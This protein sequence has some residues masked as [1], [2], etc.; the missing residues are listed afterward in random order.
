MNYVASPLTTR[1]TGM[2]A[3]GT[4]IFD[5]R[6]H[7]YNNMF[8][9]L[10]MNTP[11]LWRF[12]NDL[13]M[14]PELEQPIFHYRQEDILTP[15]TKIN[16]A[17]GYAADATSLVVDDSRPFAVN[18]VAYT[19]LNDGAEAMLV[20][21]VNHTTRALTVTR[22]YGD[23]IAQAIVDN[24]VIMA[25]ASVLAEKGSFN[26]GTGQVPASNKFNY[27]GFWADSISVSKLQE[28]TSMLTIDGQEIG[29][30]SKAVKDLT[31]QN[32]QKLQTD[33]LYSRRGQTQG[34]GSAG[35][36]YRTNG[37]IQ[38]LTDVDFD[39]GLSGNTLNVDGD[40]S[41]LTWPTFSRWLDTLFDYTVSGDVKYAWAG[42]KFWIALQAMFRDMSSAP[43]LNYYSPDIPY[44]NGSNTIEVTTP[45]GG[46][47]VFFL[48][49]FGFS[50]ERGAAGNC[51]IL[52]MDQVTLRT[53][54][55]YGLMTWKPDIQDNDSFVNKDGVYGSFG[56]EMYHP[57][58]SGLIVEAPNTTY[59]NNRW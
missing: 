24:Q 22:E 57:E 56:I 25:G 1:T 41:N 59:E 36:V 52:D 4:S 13:R 50:R 16:F 20:T 44:A 11:L 54:K 27:C 6:V 28:A 32:M 51:V 26:T 48:D 49:R 34:A 23:T 8:S 39:S 9:F 19:T 5:L 43:V 2:D 33:V 53:H 29:K 30:M 15:V 37:I 35:T 18:S 42:S 12:L 45:T 10:N 14:G 38:Q 46:K 7:E 17:A 58:L 21:A 3:L 55:D 40:I 31:I 47:V